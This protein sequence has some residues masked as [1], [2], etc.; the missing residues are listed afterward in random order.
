MAQGLKKWILDNLEGLFILF[1]IIM[2]LFTIFAYGNDMKEIKK[3]Y[4]KYCYCLWDNYLPEYEV[5]LSNLQLKE[6]TKW[7]LLPLQ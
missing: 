2:L 3:H 6:E 5:N 1:L 7:D 4:D